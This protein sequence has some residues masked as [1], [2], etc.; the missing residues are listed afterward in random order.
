[1]T[2][3]LAVGEWL[4]ANQLCEFKLR[5]IYVISC[6]NKQCKITK[7]HKCKNNKE[8]YINYHL[9]TCTPSI[10]YGATNTCITIQFSCEFWF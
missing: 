2:L 9:Y 6:L 4:Y 1:M 8:Q 3:I 7:L 5:Q 10:F